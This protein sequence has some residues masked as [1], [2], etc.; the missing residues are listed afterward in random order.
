MNPLLHHN[1]YEEE[2]DEE[3][4]TR[5]K[6]DEDSDPGNDTQQDIMKAVMER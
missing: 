1:A 3:L 2:S 5:D 6:K 4:A